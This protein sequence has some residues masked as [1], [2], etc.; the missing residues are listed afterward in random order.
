M[1]IGDLVNHDIHGFGII[2]NKDAYGMAVY[3]LEGEIIGWFS[4]HELEVLC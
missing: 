1:Q 2:V 4:F 3:M